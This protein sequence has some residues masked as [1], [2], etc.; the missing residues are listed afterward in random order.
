MRRPDEFLLGSA[1]SYRL[2]AIRSKAACLIVISGLM[3]FHQ[4]ALEIAQND[5]SAQAHRA[6]QWKACHVKA[7]ELPSG[8]KCLLFHATFARLM[9]DIKKDGEGRTLSLALILPD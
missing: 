1:V 7:T 8:V 9:R 2:G 5:F 6:M 4:F 3:A